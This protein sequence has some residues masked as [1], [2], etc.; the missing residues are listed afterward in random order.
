MPLLEDPLRSSVLIVLAL[1]ALTL[2]AG[3]ELLAQ[4][5][6]INQRGVYATGQAPAQLLSADLN[7]D[8]LGDL[9][10]VDV[11]SFT[12]T[13]MVGA[14]DGSFGSLKTTVLPCQPVHGQA[15]DFN[16]DGKADV[17]IVCIASPQIYVLPGKGDGTFGTPLLTQAP[18][19]VLGFL[20]YLRIAIADFNLDGNLDVAFLSFDLNQA[21]TGIAGSLYI[22]PGKGNGTFGAAQAISGITG[23]SLSTGDLN[24]DGKPDLIVSSPRNMAISAINGQT[25]QAG[26]VTILLGNGDLTFR[27]AS[28]FTPAFGPATVAVADTNADGIPDLVVDG[29]QDGLAIYAGKGDGT[30]TQRYSQTGTGTVGLPVVAAMFGNALPDIV[31]PYASCCKTSIEF[32]A[33][34]SD[35][36]YQTISQANVGFT[37]VSVV[38]GDFDGDGRPDIAAVSFPASLIDN[39]DLLNYVFHSG[40]PNSVPNGSVYVELDTQTFAIHLANSASFAAGVTS[41]GAIASLF[42][43]QMATTRNGLSAT[44]LPLPT[45]LN[46]AS[47]AVTDAQ[48]T[49]RS[50]S[51]FYASPTQINFLVPDGTTTGKATINVTAGVN[52]FSTT[53]NIATLGPGIFPLNAGGLAAANLIRVAAGGTQTA[54]NVYQL[55]ANNNIVARPISFGAG[56]DQLY[57]TIYGTGFKNAQSATVTIG[58]QTVAAPYAG[59]QGTQ[60][61][62]D[63]INVGPLPR[64]LAGQGKVNV[65]VNIDGSNANTTYLTFQ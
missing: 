17:L 56:T 62:L 60:A 15:A 37:S 50:A 18:V 10:T 6:K 63:Q 58:G 26:P 38:S 33:S 1:F 14:G 8:G 3:S 2:F 54:E 12:L 32:L 55:D 4:P 36:T 34:N 35:G 20:D 51:L 24:G 61:G 46:N 16:K 40:S 47:V 5:P 53:A 43:A 29:L 28:S 64:S 48:G 30:F 52:S 11:V 31:I 44:T 19:N 41:P 22:L 49:I 57:L 23:A 21:T 42:G 27:N 9:V 25:P 13:T 39:T 59:A 45:S 7:G 65:T